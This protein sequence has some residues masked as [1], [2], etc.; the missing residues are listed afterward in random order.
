MKG[1]NNLRLGLLWLC[2]LLARSW[3]WINP[4][5][6]PCRGAAADHRGALRSTDTMVGSRGQ[7]GGPC[8]TQSADEEH[9]R[10]GLRRRLTSQSFELIEFND[11]LEALRLYHEQYGDLCMKSSWRVPSTYPWPERFRGRW[12]ARIVSVH[13]LQT[14]TT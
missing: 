6:F 13:Q 7:A 5:S 8:T 10:K 4:R 3:S 12:L 11:A 1:H 9:S 14:A 2:V